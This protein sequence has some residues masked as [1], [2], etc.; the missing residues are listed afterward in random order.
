MRVAVLSICSVTAHTSS[1]IYTQKL[2]MFY[3]LSGFY[4]NLVSAA[5]IN[6][7]SHRSICTFFCNQSWLLATSSFSHTHFNS[8]VSMCL[9]T[10]RTT[11]YCHHKRFVPVNVDF[12]LYGWNDIDWKYIKN[13]HSIPYLTLQYYNKLLL[14][15]WSTKYW[16]AAFVKLFLKEQ[17]LAAFPSEARFQ[18]TA[19]WL[20]KA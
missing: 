7:L 14:L 8:K 10:I 12:T 2:K 16:T 19:L 15:L 5:A 6:P 4:T 13:N 18:E 11:F 20:K 9:L 1:F 17:L 3:V